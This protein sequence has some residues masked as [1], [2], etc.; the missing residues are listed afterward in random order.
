MNLFR[1]WRGIALF[2]GGGGGG[3]GGWGLSWVLYNELWI[4]NSFL[5]LKL[6]EGKKS[7]TYKIMASVSNAIRNGGSPSR[8]KV[9]SWLRAQSRLFHQ[10]FFCLLFPKIRNKHIIIIFPPQSF[11][12]ER[13]A[14]LSSLWPHSLPRPLLPL[15]QPHRPIRFQTPLYLSSN[16]RGD[17]WHPRD[18]ARV[19]LPEMLCFW[20]AFFSCW[21]DRT[22][23]SEAVWSEKSWEIFAEDSSQ[24]WTIKRVTFS[25]SRLIKI[26]DFFDSVGWIPST[27]STRQKELGFSLARKRCWPVPG[28]SLGPGFVPTCLLWC[29]AQ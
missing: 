16:H 27:V 22:G 1:G 29:R 3:G 19:W 25:V 24:M 5:I 2:Q 9:N 15:P 26:C 8:F 17:P 12:A 10:H 13:Q 7:R 28:W 23:S 4:H 18:S 6:W 14:S 11:S 21:G 20:W